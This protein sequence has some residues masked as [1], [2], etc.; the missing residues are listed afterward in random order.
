MGRQFKAGFVLTTPDRVPARTAAEVLVHHR[1]CRTSRGPTCRVGRA[2]QGDGRRSQQGGEM[3]HARVMAYKHIG[4]H[5]HPG[6][7]PHRESAQHDRRPGHAEEQPFDHLLVCRS[8]KEQRLEALQPFEYF[9]ENLRLHTL[10]SAAASRMDDSQRPPAR[11]SIPGEM[12]VRVRLERLRGHVSDRGL[13]VIY[14]RDLGIPLAL[15]DARQRRGE[16]RLYDGRHCAGALQCSRQRSRVI[17]RPGYRQVAPAESVSQQ[18]IGGRHPT[19]QRRAHG[20][21]SG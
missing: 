1:H 4:L 3:G 20:R 7:Q 17:A 14:A 10:M 8:L 9:E 21:L 6:Q 15:M 5:Q 13:S 16:G 18:R 11:Q 12:R 19:E 2:E